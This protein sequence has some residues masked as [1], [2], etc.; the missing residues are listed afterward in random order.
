[1]RFVYLTCEKA[2]SGADLKSEVASILNAAQSYARITKLQASGSLSLDRIDVVQD[3]VVPDD[4]STRPSSSQDGPMEEGERPTDDRLLR[5]E[6][7]PEMPRLD[8]RD[9]QQHQTPMHVVQQEAAAAYLLLAAA[10]G[11]RS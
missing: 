10:A 2:L 9:S 6:R 7:E 8:A 11:A 5:Q 4:P 1:M 3:E